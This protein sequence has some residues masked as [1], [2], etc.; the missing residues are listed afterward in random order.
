[1]GHGPKQVGPILSDFI[2]VINFTI[3]SIKKSSQSG[4]V[5]RVQPILSTLNFLKRVFVQQA[6]IIKTL[7]KL[8]YGL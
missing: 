1:M 3:Q 5:Q 6:N 8:F 7:G 4:L 2:R